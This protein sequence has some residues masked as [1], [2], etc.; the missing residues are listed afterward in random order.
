M[1]K[2]RQ[3]KVIDKVLALIGGRDGAKRWC[4]KATAQDVAGHWVDARDKR[5]VRWCVLG[6]LEKVTSSSEIIRTVLS[7]TG[8]TGTNLI[9]LNDTQ[10]RRAVLKALRK[11]KKE[12]QK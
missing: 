5:A 10:G 4:K 2:A 8:T 7:A 1:T 3:I 11:Y 12:L 9:T 6:A